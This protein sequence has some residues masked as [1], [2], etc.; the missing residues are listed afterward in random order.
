MKLY[1]SCHRTPI[2]SQTWD[3]TIDETT[4]N[5]KNQH[6]PNK[7]LQLQLLFFIP[8]TN[9][10]LLQHPQHSTDS[11]R[12]YRYCTIKKKTFFGDS[13]QLNNY[14]VEVNWWVPLARTKPVLTSL[15]HTHI[16]IS[17]ILNWNF[18]FF[19]IFLLN[20]DRL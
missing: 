20:F 10:A 19:R 12:I 8:T 4:S 16:V 6:Q 18:E 13:N 11:L 7:L 14:W 2:S 17:I 9:H 3:S 1:H 5:I 15:S